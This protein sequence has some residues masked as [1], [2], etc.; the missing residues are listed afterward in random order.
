MEH[1]ARTRGHEGGSC[2]RRGPGRAAE[3]RGGRQSPGSTAGTR[4]PVPEL[5]GQAGGGAAPREHLTPCQPPFVLP[6]EE[7]GRPG[8]PEPLPEGRGRSGGTEEQQMGWTPA[9]LYR[10]QLRSEGHPRP[11]AT[12]KGRAE[13]GIGY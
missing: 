6:P 10:V 2:A 4:E 9:R 12:G 7:M 13:S 11:P 3:P 8:E 1:F 5:G